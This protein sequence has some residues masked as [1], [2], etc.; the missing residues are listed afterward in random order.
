MH[1]LGRSAFM[2]VL[3]QK[4][5]RIFSLTLL[6]TIFGAVA[7]LWLGR[8]VQLRA[9][10]HGLSDY[11]YELNRHAEETAIEIGV[12]FRRLNSAHLPSCS[13]QEIQAMQA[14]T[15]RSRDLKDI[16][17]TGD[18]KLYCSAFLGRLPH[19]YSEGPP[20]LRLGTQTN[21]YTNVAVLLAAFEG[22]H[23]TVIESANIDAVLSPSAFDRWDRPNVRYM[24]AVVNRRTAQ[25]A[26]IAGTVMKVDPAKLMAR[27]LKT[28]S[29]GV[30][31]RSHCSDT[32]PVCAVTAER[33]ADVWGWSR[34]MQITYSA[35]G[36]FGGFSLALALALLYLQ[37]IAMSNQLHRDIRKN[38]PSL[39]MVYQPILDIYTHRCVGAEALIRWTDQEGTAVSPDVFVRIAE[40]KGFIGELTAFVVRRS[41]RELAPLLR[42]YPDLTLSINIAASDMNGDELMLLL[43]DHVCAAG[44]HPHQIALELTERSTADLAVV[45]GAIKR[46]CGEGY[47]VHIDDFGT[48]FSSLSY[49]DKLAV[50]AIKIDRSFTQTIGTDA[51][52]APILPQIL[53]MAEAL[54][55]SVI[56]EGVETEMQTQFLQATGKPLHAQGWYFGK[57]MSPEALRRFLEP[58]AQKNT[59]QLEPEPLET[60]SQV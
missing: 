6:G 38:S 25:M 27:E 32:Y 60:V 35:M 24:V 51:V 21:I 37:T 36:A 42:Q 11:A 50:N 41:T 20:T 30:V 57:P 28:T 13:D 43:K 17:R 59:P 31:Y 54:G 4:R 40:E 26:P 9:A 23:A 12:I 2:R 44:I 46:L 56:V 48:G 1:H 16:G 58:K 53:S 7:G 47:K 33:I 10:A 8:A 15:F 19:P 29:N 49:L 14:E 22:N 18:G 39:R 5:L 34:S 45:R 3:R 52:T 55:L